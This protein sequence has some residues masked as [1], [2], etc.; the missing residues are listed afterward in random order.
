M[1]WLALRP[2]CA[3]SDRCAAREVTHHLAAQPAPTEASVDATVVADRGAVG[4]GP[5]KVAARKLVAT[6]L[7][8]AGDTGLSDI[9]Q[10]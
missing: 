5:A 1:S 6:P 9:A 2:N 7:M 4:S 10:F 3:G 8:S